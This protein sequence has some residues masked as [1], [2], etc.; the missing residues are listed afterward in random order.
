MRIITT[1][2]LAAALTAVAA[3]ANAAEKCTLTKAT[4]V[5]MIRLLGD[6]RDVLP[7]TVAGKQKY[8]LLDTGGDITQISRAAARDL[9]LPIFSGNKTLVGITGTR[10]S[11]AARIPEFSIGGL[12]RANAVFPISPNLGVA[13]GEWFD[14]ILAPDVL[15]FYDVDVDFGTDTF[16]LFTRDH[17]PGGV[18]YWTAPAVAILPIIKAEG[19]SMSVPVMLDGHTINA[20]FDTGA[21][22]STLRVDLAKKFFGPFHGLC[23]YAIGERSG[24]RTFSDV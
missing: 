9:H 11:N 17:C 22:T 12:G 24:R 21:S 16:N 5:Q 7:L 19:N 13:S 20:T 2:A 3:A 23:R 10:S 4:S 15:G 18:V 6:G 1:F 14:G 8:F